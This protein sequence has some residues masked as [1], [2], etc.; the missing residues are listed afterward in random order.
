MINRDYYENVASTAEVGVRKSI[1][2]GKD[3]EK[4]SFAVFKSGFVPDPF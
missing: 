3:C 2:G 4:L 1:D